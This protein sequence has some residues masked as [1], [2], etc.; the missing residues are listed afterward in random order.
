[1]WRKV[2]ILQEF[3]LSSKNEEAKGKRTRRRS[4]EQDNRRAREKSVN[5]PKP[6]PDHKLCHATFCSI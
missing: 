4:T 1:M 2:E 3:R 6:Q 5:K